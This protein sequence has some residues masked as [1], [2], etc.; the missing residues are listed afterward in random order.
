MSELWVFRGTQ[1]V[2]WRIPV[3]IVFRARN[4]RRPKLGLLAHLEPA[5]PL[6][7]CQ[8]V[9]LNQHFRAFKAVQNVDGRWQIKGHVPVGPCPNPLSRGGWRYEVRLR[10]M[11]G[12]KIAADDPEDHLVWGARR[13]PA[14]KFKPEEK[15]RRAWLEELLARG[16]GDSYEQLA[17]FWREF[18]LHLA[19][20]LLNEEQPVDCFLFKLHNC[21]LRTNWKEWMGGKPPKEPRH[22]LWRVLGGGRI[23]AFDV[24]GEHA[25]RHI[26]LE[27]TREWWKLVRKVEGRRRYV[28]GREEYARMFQKSLERFALT[29]WRLFWRHR[30]EMA[31]ASADRVPH[32]RGGG[33]R[34]VPNPVARSMRGE[35]YKLGRA[36]TR[37]T[38]NHLRWAIK[39]AK[40]A[41]PRAHGRLPAVSDL[42]PA[43]EAVRQ[44]AD[45]RAGSAVDQSGDGTGG[46]DGVLLCADPKK[47]VSKSEMLAA[48]AGLDHDGLA[49]GT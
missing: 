27:H 31:Q 28:K 41:L 2:L 26:E 1:P 5:V 29:A 18:C 47:L 16:V 40:E 3:R 7:G 15:E 48:R 25:L 23:L 37:A 33:F 46:S 42:R 22:L 35:A 19:H 34:F 20:T 4:A 38:L 8:R 9:A 36:P 32:G 10:G 30:E 45:A 14:R 12:V 21:P 49:G 24:E 13:P 44:P 17:Y 6:L 11:G 43:V 39:R